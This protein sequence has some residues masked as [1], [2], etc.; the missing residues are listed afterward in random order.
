MGI[1]TVDEPVAN[2]WYARE[3]WSEHLSCV[4]LTTVS[5]YL[6]KDDHVF[7]LAAGRK[8]KVVMLAQVTSGGTEP[9]PH[10]RDPKRWP[11]SFTL[12]PLVW[13]AVNEA[14]SV[15]GVRT[16]RGVVAM[17]SG[18]RAGKLYEALGA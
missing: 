15:P 6:C 14:V 9:A 2:D 17:I 5:R 12:R 1:G 16:P 4:W 7:A 13:R 3:P 8:S 10:P 18:E 11:Y